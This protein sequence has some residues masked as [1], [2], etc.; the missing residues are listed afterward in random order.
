ML[1]PP[2]K[3]ANEHILSYWKDHIKITRSPLLCSFLRPLS[4]NQF[5]TYNVYRYASPINTAAAFPQIQSR[6]FK[7]GGRPLLSLKDDDFQRGWEKLLDFG[8]PRDAWFVCVHC[9]EEGYISGEGQNYRNADVTNYIPAMEAIIERGG[10][11][12]RLGDPS[13]K[14]MPANKRIIDYAHLENRSDWM[15][16]FLCGACKFFFG[17]ASG[18]AVVSGVF[19]VPSAIANQAPVSVVLPYLPCD[20]GIPKLLYSQ[21]EKRY[22]KF[23][24]ILG[25][26]IGNFRFDSLYKD[27]GT[28]VI[29]NTPEDIEALALEMLDR[30]NGVIVY[31]A[32]DNELQERF[33]S[34][35]DENHYSYGSEARVGREFLR[36]YSLL[37]N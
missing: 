19:G 18:L 6:Y 3:V 5:T 26:A 2:G 9:R 23:S 10:W 30:I 24:E 20:I 13:M 1:A 22:L 11:V 33:K 14:A 31:T 16:V 34:L 21:R 37:L 8:I 12:I 36:K 25:S 35:M 4:N 27:C 29:D 28:F 15:D 17:S 7:T 32:E